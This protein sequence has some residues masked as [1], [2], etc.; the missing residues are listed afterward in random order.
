MVPPYWALPIAIIESSLGIAV[1]VVPL[2]VIALPVGDIGSAAGAAGAGCAGAEGC[3]GDW[4]VVTGASAQATATKAIRS[5]A[6]IASLA[7][8]PSSS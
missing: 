4:L 5:M 6:L 3:W 8:I 1:E 7:N 2:E